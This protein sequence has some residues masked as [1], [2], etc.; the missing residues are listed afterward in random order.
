MFKEDQ[1]PVILIFKNRFCF[2][3]PVG[4]QKVPFSIKKSA[5]SDSAKNERFLSLT[6]Y[7]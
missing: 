7:Y 4:G 2:E 5:S 6:K 3:K 1:G